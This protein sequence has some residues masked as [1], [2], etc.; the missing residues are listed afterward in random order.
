MTIAKIRWVKLR[1][2]SLAWSTREAGF[3]LT[4]YEEYPKAVQEVTKKGSSKN[5]D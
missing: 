3:D 2:Y 1:D 4:M 5:S